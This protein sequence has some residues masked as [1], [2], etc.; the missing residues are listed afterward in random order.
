MIHVVEWHLKDIFCLLTSPKFDFGDIKKSMF[1]VVASNWEL[2][3]FL[4]TNPKC[5]VS[6]E[7]M[8][9]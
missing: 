2:I 9:F 4:L 7:R 8:A 6:R 5:D 1:L 3:F